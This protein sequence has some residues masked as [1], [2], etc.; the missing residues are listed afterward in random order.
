MPTMSRVRRALVALAASVPLGI[1]CS[2]PFVPDYNNPTIGDVVNDAAQL[3]GQASGLLAGDRERHAFQILVLE[4]MGRDAYRIDVADP[5][6]LL[7]PLG[8]FSPGAFLVDFTWNSLYQTIRGAQLLTRG[9]DASTSLSATEKAAARGYARTLQALEYIR[10]IETRDTLGVPILSGSGTLDPV[11]CKPAVLAYAV[12]LLDSAAADLAAGGTAF[13]FTLSSGFTGNGTFNTPTTFRRFNR[14]LAAKALTYL[15]FIDYARNGSVGTAALQSALTALGESFASETGTLR[16]GV[17]HVYSTASGDLANANYDPSVYRA[18]PKVLADAEA[19]DLR[20]SKVRRDATARKENSDGTIAS[21]ILFTNITGPT[22]PLPILTNEELLLIR[23]EVLWGLQRDAEALALVNTVRS[24]A[25]GLPARTAASLATRTDLLRE[26]LRQKRYSLL[27]ES[28][29]RF[30]DMRMFGF[31][32]ELGSELGGGQLGPR[33]IPF[34]Q[35]EIDAR[36]G[37]LTC[38]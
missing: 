35:A 38:S 19:G 15:G 18:N 14:G 36:G 11:R 5:R 37:I 2:D 21:D 23:A 33:V 17:Y 1:A 25:G 6:Y 13:P 7:Q 32:N 22:T 8:Q 20:L 10:L 34:P 12:A 27:F 28:G 16:D 29:A 4:T 26:I 30:V 9:V 31:F 3:Q 24:R